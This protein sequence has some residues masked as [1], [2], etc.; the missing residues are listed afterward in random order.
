MV[1]GDVAEEVGDGEDEVAGGALLLD[2][3]VE[4]GDDGDGGAAGGV[5]LVGDDGADG[6]EG[7]EAFAAGPLAVG[8]LDVAGGDVVDA[9]VAAN[10]GA[11]VFVG[12]D[13][14]A[15]AADDDAE[16]ALVVD[17]VGEGGHADDAVGGEERGWRLEEEERLF[18]DFVA[19]LGGVVA[20]VAAYAED[21]GGSDGREEVEVGE[22][23]GLEVDGG[24]GDGKA[25]EDAGGEVFLRGLHGE[26]G[27]ED[28]VALFDEGVAREGGSVFGRQ[29]LQ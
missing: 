9:D 10:V 12:A 23:G 18:G 6:A 8:L 28:S 26:R 5:D 4:A 3:A 24:G 13:L 21:L 1:G 17:A 7:V 22:R 20:V 27:P 15:A 16:L 25:A 29:I 19:E 11:D 2:G 14:V